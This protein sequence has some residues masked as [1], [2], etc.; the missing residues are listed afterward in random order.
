MV[1][2]LS[3][4]TDVDAALIVGGLSLQAQAAALRAG[5]A[6]VVGT[7]GAAYGAGGVG[8]WREQQQPARCNSPAH[9]H[10]LRAHATARAVTP[11]HMSPLTRPRD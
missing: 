11:L 7:P 4:F 10:A 2:R 8:W 5:P 6:I 9:P 3:Q 1:Q